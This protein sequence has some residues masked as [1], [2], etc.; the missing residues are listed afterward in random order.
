MPFWRAPWFAITI[1]ALASLLAAVP[2]QTVH[3][4]AARDLLW[5]RDCLENGLCRYATPAMVGGL[6]HGTLWMRWMVLTRA[7]GSG[8]TG[9]AVLA[10]GLLAAAVGA[11]AYWTTVRFGRVSAWIAAALLLAF[12]AMNVAHPR[13][14]NLC[15]LPVGAVLFHGFLG[16]VARTGATRAIITASYAFYLLTESHIA[17]WALAPV[18]VAIVVM[19]GARAAWWGIAIVAILNLTLSWESTRANATELAH[20]G[21]LPV[22]LVG[23]V[24]CVVMAVRTRSRWQALDAE[25][26][27]LWLQGIAVGWYFLVGAAFQTQSHKQFADR[28]LLPI[29]PAVVW[30]V[31]LILQKLRRPAIRFRWAV[32]LFGAAVVVVLARAFI[33][34]AHPGTLSYDEAEKL[35][36]FWHSRGLS[37][38][39]IRASYRGAERADALAGLAVFNKAAQSGPAQTN[40]IQ[41]VMKVPSTLN[42]PHG[43]DAVPLSDRQKALVGPLDAW[44]RED[45]I[46]VS[47]GEPQPESAVV[48]GP[49]LAKQYCP[50]NAVYSMF[51][52]WSVPC[53]YGAPDEQHLAAELHRE[54]RVIYELPVQ[55]AGDDAEHV[56]DVLASELRGGWE[57]T[58]RIEGVTGVDVRWE[59]AG[60]RIVL[61]RKGA[62][63]GTIRF[64]RVATAN[65]LG[66]DS[67]VRL[68]YLE[69]RAS[70]SEIR[71]L[72]L[73][74]R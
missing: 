69:T 64:S 28:Y 11:M 62:A 30:A 45:V 43:W 41:R 48:L 60:Q 50:P 9:Q 34:A 16:D 6:M 65:A 70:E 13:L 4:D 53:G 51:A 15:L 35:A 37:D 20:S 33:A 5:A 7:L 52:D 38:A 40:R 61:T 22:A 26:R 66:S 67:N 29:F 73:R 10:S 24:A 68:S 57:K 27:F 14:S 18:F 49:F 56:V 71:V 74:P 36:G 44:V 54:L 19:S 31:C 8:P 25:K 42:V 72:A 46:R 55:I 47:Y 39:Q 1:L 23:G 59:N 17:G 2:F 21:V 12:S 63:A 32:L 3:L 58:L